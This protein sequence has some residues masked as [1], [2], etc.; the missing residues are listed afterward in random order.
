MTVAFPFHLDAVGRTARPV[1]SDAH[2]RE[3]LVQL[4]LTRPGE[5]V[6]RPQLGC[7]AGDLVFGP[8]SPEIAAALSVTIATAITEHLGDLIRVKDL[9]VRAHEG[10]LRVDLSYD[11]LAEGRS[12]TT[13]IGL[14][15]QT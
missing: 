1:S 10:E 8:A 12:V 5:R 2:L 4:L 14:P 6:N 9:R 7:G 13:S 3:L 15:G 11:V